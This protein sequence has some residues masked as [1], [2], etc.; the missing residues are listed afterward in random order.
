MSEA[1]ELLK[2]ILSTLRE[3]RDSLRSGGAPGERQASSGK[4]GQVAGDRELDS[5]WGDPVVRKDPKKWT[6]DSYAGCHFSECIPEYLD[7]LADLYD[8]MGD[9]DEKDN[10]MH[11]GKP[12]APYKRRDAA[13][14]RGWAKRLREGWQRPAADSQSDGAAPA[15][16][17]AGSGADDPLPF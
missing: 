8:W 11:K 15:G 6:G 10:K 9:M 17:G 2:E 4:G 14:A 5:E 3:I 12:T 16:N 1:T 7:E 13:R